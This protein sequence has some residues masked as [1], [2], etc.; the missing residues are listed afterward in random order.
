MSV[1]SWSSFFTPYN[2]AQVRRVVPTSAGVYTLWVNYKSGGWE[3]FYVGKADN[4]EGRLLDHLSAKEEN[5][6]IKGNIAYMCGFSWIE[7]TTE[8]ERSGAEKYLY[9]RMKPECNQIDPGGR[10]LQIPLPPTPARTA[11][12]T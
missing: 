5:M 2:E 10:P 1:G 4:L 7:I 9:D 11:P 6:C 12:T 8:A 3:C